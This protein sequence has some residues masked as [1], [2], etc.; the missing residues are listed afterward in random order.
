MTRW[1]K[2]IMQLG[3]GGLCYGHHGGEIIE[4]EL[5]HTEIDIIIVR[6]SE[7]EVRQYTIGRIGKRALCTSR[8]IVSRLGR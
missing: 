4:V 7:R 8:M 2:C 1:R 5:I 3:V 6:R